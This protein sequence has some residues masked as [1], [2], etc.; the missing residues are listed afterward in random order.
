MSIQE[1]IEKYSSRINEMDK[2]IS[3]CNSAKFD[4]DARL[5]ETVNGLCSTIISYRREITQ[6]FLDDL[7]KVT[8]T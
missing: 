4:P 8:K 2:R 1:L 7:K 6:E 5:T 3:E